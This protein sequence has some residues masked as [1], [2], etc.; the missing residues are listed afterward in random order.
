ML[1]FKKTNIL[2]LFLEPVD[3]STQDL[4]L[5]GLSRVSLECDRGISYDE[6]SCAAK[7]LNNSKA[8]GLDGLPAEFYKHIG[9]KLEEISTLF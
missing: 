1:I 5:S 9:T 8:P 6:V 7:Q 4:L 3:V 2:S